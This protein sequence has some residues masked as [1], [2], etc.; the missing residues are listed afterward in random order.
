MLIPPINMMIKIY[1]S[2]DLAFTPVM[3]NNGMAQKGIHE[4]IQV[5]IQ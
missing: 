4:I 2:I 3:A 1:G 5:F